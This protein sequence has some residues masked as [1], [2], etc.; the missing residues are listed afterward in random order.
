MNYLLGLL[1]FWVFLVSL[2]FGTAMTRLRRVR[3]RPGQAYSPGKA[4]VTGSI[5]QPLLQPVEQALQALGFER[6]FWLAVQEPTR[7]DNHALNL[8]VWFHPQFCTYAQVAPHPLPEAHQ[9]AT[10]DFLTLYADGTVVNTSNGLQHFLVMEVENWDQADGYLPTL[11]AHWDF[12][13]QRIAQQT[14]AMPCMLD[15]AGLCDLYNDYLHRYLQGQLQQGSMMAAADG[16]YRVSWKGAWRMVRRQQAAATKMKVMTAQMQQ[17]NHT[18]HNPAADVLA[19]QRHE[20]M[21]QG[22]QSGMGGKLWLLVISLAAFMVSFGVQFDF[23]YVALL[24]GVLLLHELGHLAAMALFG[25]RDLQILF[26]PFLG[27]VALGRHHYC[28]AWQRALIDLAGPVPGILLAAALWYAGVGEQSG[29]WLQVIALLLILNY[30]NLMPIQPLDGGHLLHLLLM[31]RWPWLQVA[32]WVGSVAGLLGLAWWLESPLLAAL[33]FLFAF[34]LRH[35]AREA[36]VLQQVRQQQ[37]T[38]EQASEQNLLALYT[39]MQDLK[40]PWN[41]ANRLQAARNLLQKMS[42]PFPSVRESL[43][44]LALYVTVLVGTPALVLMEVPHLA[45]KLVPMSKHEKPDWDKKLAQANTDEK[46][47]SVL[48]RA[49]NYSHWTGDRAQALDYFQQAR[50]LLINTGQAQSRAMADLLIQLATAQAGQEY[51]AGKEALV[52]A[53]TSLDQALAMLESLPATADIQYAKT[54]ALEAQARLANV[55]Q[56]PDAALALYEQALQLHERAEAVYPGFISDNLMQQAIILNR[57]GATAQADVRFEQALA[58]LAASKA[59]KEEDVDNEDYYEDGEQYWQALQ[60]FASAQ[61]DQQ[62]YADAV[63]TLD[64]HSTAPAAG[65]EYWQFQLADMRAWAQ[66]KQGQTEAAASAYAALLAQQ[67]QQNPQQQGRYVQADTLAKVLLVQHAQ[68]GGG[69]QAHAMAQDDAFS[70]LLQTLDER[71]LDLDDYLKHLDCECKRDA[72][73]Y[74]LQQSLEMRDA[75]RL[76]GGMDRAP[77]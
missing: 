53:E 67:Q 60:N 72:G 55:R 6:A 1:I 47:L 68:A 18:P 76:Y 34:T 59:E 2:T 58:V 41:F 28:P 3:W 25:F 14:A 21:T 4:D 12:H 50:T 23:T 69:N 39:A 52:Q 24:V 15:A 22:R 64:R 56:Q 51:S 73:G 10:V 66:L 19:H 46:R 5:E 7:Q 49:G 37:G 75:V 36:K 40:M 27:A 43:F 11:A 77:G 63:A 29:L 35:Q 9:F 57:Q 38:T 33:G 70:R 44:G 31:Q 54:Q 13:C 8:P 30:L 61:L 74:E 20:A 26:I 71:D 45:Q 32:F 65:G 62:R 48:M 42:I 16:L 17:A